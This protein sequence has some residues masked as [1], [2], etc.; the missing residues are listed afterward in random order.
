MPLR[1]VVEGFYG[2]PWSPEA[3]L[4]TISFLGAHGMNAYVYAPKDDPR[5]RSE[6]RQGYDAGER[7]H[8][9]EVVRAGV[10]SGVRIGFAISPGL[11]VEYE[12]RT[13][14][15]AL[16][17]KL[18]AMRDLGIDW[19]VLALDDIPLRAGLAAEQASL[20]SWMHSALAGAML[21]LVPTEYVGTRPTEYLGTLAAGLPAAVDVMWTG[22]TVCSPTITR[23]EAEAWASALGGRKPIVWDNYPVNDG[24]MARSLHL[25]PYRGRE[26]D[27]SDAVDGVLLNP[28][29]QA[30][31]S[32]VALA[33]A[34]EYLRDP[35]GYDPD[36]AWER[37]LDRV[38]GRYAPQVRALAHACA[39]SALSSPEALPLHSLLDDL[40][41]RID[42]PDWPDAVAKVRDH[43]EAAR[44]AGDGWAEDDALRAEVT[45]WLAQAASEARAGLAALGL[46]QAV[47]PVARFDAHGVGRA[48]APDAEG[49][50]QAAFG[51]VFSWSG[52]R[53]GEKVTFGPR[54]A[55]YP[56]VVQ[57]ADGRP[58]LDVG[59]T[60][61]EDR[62][63]I[64][65]LCRLALAAYRAWAASPSERLEVTATSR[66]VA[67]EPPG[68]FT[69]EPVAPMILVRAGAGVT[70]ITMEQMLPFRDRR[71]E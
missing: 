2:P 60:V 36:A 35:A 50:M 3:R 15:A 46:I 6:W 39:D 12:G 66:A 54:F 19:F 8:F 14:R 17:A 5:H 52:A 16:L 18:S 25:G 27:L 58:G 22:P 41:A 33:T 68:A 65:R 34:A 40:E 57:L 67:L 45:P 23:A 31:A 64:D 42:G 24:T 7:A 53:E 49:T 48:A 9:A 55:I 71:L 26:P 32:W 10:D 59:A 47:R 43:L 30:R 70:R 44:H 4:A 69:L 61:L 37:A 20:T 11:D 56:A 62:C 63:A 21:T 38:G 51:M 1:G 29:N 28:M 13:D